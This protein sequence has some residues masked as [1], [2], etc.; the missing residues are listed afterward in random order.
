MRENGVA[1][2]APLETEVLR[3]IKN[4]TGMN[5]LMKEALK[6]SVGW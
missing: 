2:D 3:R 6:V 4:F 5:K 1:S